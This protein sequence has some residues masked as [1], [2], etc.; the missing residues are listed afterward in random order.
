MDVEIV[1]MSISIE[2]RV[3]MMDTLDAIV[4]YI[5]NLYG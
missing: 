4:L 1:S 5:T 2:V 3:V